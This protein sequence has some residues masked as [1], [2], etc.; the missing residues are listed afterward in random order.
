[1]GIYLSGANCTLTNV[2][3]NSNDRMG[4]DVGDLGSSITNFNVHSNGDDGIRIGTDDNNFTNGNI[5]GS[6]ENDVNLIST[7]VDN[8]FLNVSYSSESVGAGSDL[9]RKWYYQANVTEYYSGNVVSGVNVTANNVSGGYVLNLTTNA[10]G[11]TSVGEIIE[12]T[13]TN[14]VKTYYN[15]YTITGVNSSYIGG[16]S[17]W[18]VSAEQN[19]LHSF[20]MIKSQSN[21]S[22]NTGWNLVSLGFNTTE[23]STD[24]NVSLVAGWNLVG[25]AGDINISLSGASF[26]N[27]SGSSYTWANAIANNKVQAYGAYYDSSDS[28]A[29]FRKYKYLGSSG[30]DD[31]SFRTGKGYWIWA[32]QSGNLSLPGVGGSVS[33]ETYALTSLRF[34]NGTEEKSYLNPFIADWIEAPQY[35][36]KST[37]SFQAATTLNSWEGYFFRSNYDNIT[38]VRQN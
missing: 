32:N 37:N 14:D 27:D 31:S 7:A 8:I 25:Y 3:A 35:F 23:A 19:G 28:N 12:Y 18:N 6:G 21:V 13:E 5:S 24:R 1:M 34:S 2:T 9:T 29:S 17:S 20:Y 33:G 22:L 4:I 30:V 38:L 36:D 11:W 26:T 16:S 10:S 15:N